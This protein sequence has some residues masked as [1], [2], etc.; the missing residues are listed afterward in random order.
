M[1]ANI[2]LNNPPE[3]PRGPRRS[4]HLSRDDRLRTQTLY[5]FAGFS[6]AKIANLLNITYNQA[7]HACKASTPTPHKH[8]GRPLRMS[9]DSLD[10]VICWISSSFENRYK[11]C[12]QIASELTLPIC[13]ETLRKMLKSRGIRA[14]TAARNPPLDPNDP[15]STDSSTPTRP[16]IGHSPSALDSGVVLQADLYRRSFD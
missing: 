9:D 13:G 8:T 14:H 7:H 4:Q 11:T 16:T 3:T 6:I 5:D 10:E 15:V 2:D 12:D 1:S